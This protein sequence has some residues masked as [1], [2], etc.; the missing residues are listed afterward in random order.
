[1]ILNHDKERTMAN[2]TVAGKVKELA[3]RGEEALGVVAE[4]VGLRARGLARQ[5]EGKIQGVAGCVSDSYDD[6][7]DTVQSVVRR[8]PVGSL[9]VVGAL[10]YLL[11][12]V[13]GSIQRRH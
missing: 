11:G 4:D 3:G 1:M 9:L 6:V 12:R 13:A 2:D 8:H 10:A 5:V 7:A